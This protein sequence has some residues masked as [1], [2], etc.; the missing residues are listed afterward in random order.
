MGLADHGVE[1]GVGLGGEATEADQDANAGEE[2]GG[3]D[4][5]R[6]RRSQWTRAAR[7]V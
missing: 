6:V 1:G 2:A 7:A 4:G 5:W 3:G